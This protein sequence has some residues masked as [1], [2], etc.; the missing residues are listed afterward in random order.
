MGF[1]IRKSF[2]GKHLKFNLSKSGI[3]TSFGIK[4]LRLGVDSKG[5]SYISGSKGMFRYR[6][7]L[8]KD[9]NKQIEEIKPTFGARLFGLILGLLLAWIPIA[10]FCSGANLEAENWKYVYLAIIIYFLPLSFNV[11]IDRK[12]TLSIIMVNILLGW[13]GIAWACLILGS[14]IWLIKHKLQK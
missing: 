9:G 3:G 1:F 12:N 4:G 14:I 7:Y 6:E 5:R 2:G 8:D 11:L 13:T 10:M